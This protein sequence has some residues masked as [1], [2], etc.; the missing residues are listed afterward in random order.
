MKRFKFL[1]V[2]LVVLVASLALAAYAVPQDVGTDWFESVATIV[3]ALAG[4]FGT[5]I[6]SLF[7]KG[8]LATARF[9]K[10]KVKNEALQAILE[11]V[12][13]TAWWVAE[14]MYEDTVK[15]MK[16]AKSSS[17]P[18]GRKITTE[19]RATLRKE[20]VARMKSRLGPEGLVALQESGVIDVEGTL[21]DAVA[22]AAQLSKER[23]FKVM[24]NGPKPLKDKE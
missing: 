4:L 14:G 3:V 6:S 20:S 15:D 19:E 21:A 24:T 2:L 13:A 23:N 8:K 10:A 22:V 16:A 7:V 17:S 12:N 9:I 5:I 11:N 1:M 18:G